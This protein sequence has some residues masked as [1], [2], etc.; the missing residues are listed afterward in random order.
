MISSLSGRVKNITPNYLVIDIGGFGVQVNVPPRISSS[1]ILGNALELHTYLVVREDS[2]TLYGFTDISD[3]SFFELLLSVTGVGPKVA[4]SILAVNNANY[5][6]NA[7][8][9]SDMKMI[10]S[11]PGL[12]KK[13]AQRLV[14]ELKDKVSIYLTTDLANDNP[15]SGQLEAALVGLGYSSKES[16]L[17]LADIAPEL[18]AKKLDLP[19]ALKLAL[20]S[21]G[22]LNK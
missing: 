14:L 10:E 1:A 21:K 16:K 15:I 22:A 9:K 8:S 3:R 7:I 17:I 12:G 5:V 13:G 18:N 2:L 4:Q 6:A 19:T 11:I 20:Q